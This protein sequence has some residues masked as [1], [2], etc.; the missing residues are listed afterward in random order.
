MAEFGAKFD[1]IKSSAKK[2]IDNPLVSQETKEKLTK[3]LDDDELFQ[4]NL[5]EVISIMAKEAEN[6]DFQYNVGRME[7]GSK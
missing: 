1:R 7:H 6:I 2:I 3:Y 4:A 5:F